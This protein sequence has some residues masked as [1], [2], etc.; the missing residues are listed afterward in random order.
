MI[1][2]KFWEDEEL[3]KESGV[4]KWKHPNLKL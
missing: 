4:S 1:I 3:W 2:D